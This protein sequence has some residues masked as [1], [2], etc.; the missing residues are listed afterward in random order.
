MVELACESDPRFEPS[1]IEQGAARSYSIDTIEKLSAAGEKPLAFLI[2][3]DA[4]AEI[5]T[6][7][8]WRDVV[9]AVEFVVVT[10][11]GAVYSTPEG[12]RVYEL[13]GVNLAVSSSQIRER[14]RAGI[15]ELPVPE[16]VKRYIESHKLYRI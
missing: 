13:P 8:R 14:V 7:H 6:W 2:G 5:E 9:A 10:R 16:A 3:A 15:P 12:A 4:F 1:R 11:P